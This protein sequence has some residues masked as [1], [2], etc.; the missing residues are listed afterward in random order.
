MYNLNDDVPSELMWII[1]SYLLRNEIEKIREIC[2]H[3]NNIAQT[4]NDKFW[5]YMVQE[6]FKKKVDMNR[7]FDKYRIEEELGH[8]KKFICKNRK[9]FPWPLHVA[10]FGVR[11]L[12]KE[13]KL[14]ENILD[15]IGCVGY[16]V[17][18]HF[19]L[20]SLNQDAAH[21]KNKAKTRS[22][23][24]V[25]IVDYQENID[26]HTKK[27]I[28]TFSALINC[29]AVD[30]SYC[31]F[32]MCSNFSKI[33]ILAQRQ[34]K[35]MQQNAKKLN[36]RYL[37]NTCE[38]NE[39]FEY[40]VKKIMVEEISKEMHRVNLLKQRSEKTSCGCCIS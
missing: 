27:L 33:E 32:L 24:F 22:Y 1:F 26:G 7:V 8:A 18:E 37:P 38:I 39:A 11:D 20:K 29:K 35:Q 36:L 9:N 5:R 12:K 3:F 21:I 34:K 6:H 31:R 19:P 4:S 28:E 14:H 10:F 15:C 30:K 16:P 25:C 40:M 17:I 23:I 2:Q 13:K